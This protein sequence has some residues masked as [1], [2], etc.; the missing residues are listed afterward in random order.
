M[1][2]SEIADLRL[3]IANVYDSLGRF[4]ESQRIY[5]EQR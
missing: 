5:A 2:P 3:E 4:A 1:N